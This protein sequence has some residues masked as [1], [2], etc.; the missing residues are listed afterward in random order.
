MKT[1][2]FKCDI[3]GCLG[4]EMVHKKI[5]LGHE[6]W[7]YKCYSGE[8]EYHSKELN[9]EFDICQNCLNNILNI[10]LEELVD[11]TQIEK[12]IEL[13]NNKTIQNIKN[14]LYPSSETKQ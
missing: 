5:K 14:Y 9:I 7:E 11:K 2:C 4:Q 12:S 10:K 8:T 6:E 1:E 13:E 3:C